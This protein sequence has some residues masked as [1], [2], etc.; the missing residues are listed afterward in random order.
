MAGSYFS[1]L[2]ILPWETE[3]SQVHPFISWVPV[4]RPGSVGPWD[5]ALQSFLK[6]SQPRMIRP[7]GR[8]GITARG[9]QGSSWNRQHLSWALK[10]VGAQ[11]TRQKGTAQTE[12]QR[13]GSLY[14]G[15]EACC[16]LGSFFFLA[17][18]G[19]SLMWD[20]GSQTRDWTQ[21]AVA[22]AP[23]PNP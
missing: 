2:C 8:K 13:S 1:G 18:A 12:A 21:A 11:Y 19:S 3:Q 17:T 23:H 16:R 20:L 7:K 10:E 9:H 4:L 22:K 5:M 14:C 6:S 15:E